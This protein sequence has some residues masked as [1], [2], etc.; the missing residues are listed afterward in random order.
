VRSTNPYN[1]EFPAEQY[2]LHK[3][4]VGKRRAMMEW[5][6]RSG[7]FSWLYRE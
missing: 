3:S 4:M 5:M 1:L 2:W 6:K 7:L